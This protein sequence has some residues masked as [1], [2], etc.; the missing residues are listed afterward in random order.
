M[1]YKCKEKEKNEVFPGFWIQ[2]KSFLQV[3][4]DL[5]K[6]ERNM[7]ILDPKG[8]DIR[9]VDIKED[10]IFIL[11]DHIG[12]PSKELRRLKKIC[13]PVT[14]GPQTYFA[15]QTITIVNNELDRRK[16]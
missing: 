15:S 16:I 10:P 2:K 11:G 5:D 4:S 8:E 6:E 12:L 1:L 14:I 13:T 3:I 7:Y 9:E